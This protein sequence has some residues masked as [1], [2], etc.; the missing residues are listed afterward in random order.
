MSSLSCFH[1]SPAHMMVGVKDQAGKPAAGQL[2]ADN[3][4]SLIS[5]PG[6]MHFYLSLNTGNGSF[7]HM[8]PFHHFTPKLREHGAENTLMRARGAERGRKRASPPVT[9][10]DS[11]GRQRGAQCV[12][13][14]GA[15]P[16]QAAASR[17]G[18][19]QGKRSLSTSELKPAGSKHL[20]TSSRKIK[21]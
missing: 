21:R 8:L 1:P 18:A 16:S 10:K 9:G 14:T 5:A 20:L 12:G 11:A 19:A 13:A 2:T 3:V 15:R 6:R 7:H 17:G 4:R